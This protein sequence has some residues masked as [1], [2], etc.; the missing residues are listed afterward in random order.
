MVRSGAGEGG[1]L[2]GAGAEQSVLKAVVT[3]DDNG[4]S[5]C[6]SVDAVAVLRG[7]VGVEGGGHRRREWP[8]V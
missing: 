5:C 7:K 4:P 3:A 8:I 2:R 1:G 6:W